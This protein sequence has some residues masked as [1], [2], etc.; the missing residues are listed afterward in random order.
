MSRAASSRDEKLDRLN[1]VADGT[2]IRHTAP[3][4]LVRGPY[5]DAGGWIN[6]ELSA[7]MLENHPARAAYRA[8]DHIVAAFVE[9]PSDMCQGF[10]LR[11][12]CH[13][14]SGE[15]ASPTKLS[16]ILQVPLFFQP[17]KENP[18]LCYA[19]CTLDLA[20][21]W[22]SLPLQPERA[23]LFAHP[24]AS[25]HQALNLYK[26]GRHPNDPAAICPCRF[27]WQNIRSPIE[28]RWRL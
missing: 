21:G 3:G 8:R 18:L 9:Q 20:P 7:L 15:L 10:C 23:C 17:Y 11:N 22:I 25:G 13:K 16:Q 27:L 19:V 6:A 24:K 1:G 12:R 28:R 26:S 14:K 5:P 4:G 2:R